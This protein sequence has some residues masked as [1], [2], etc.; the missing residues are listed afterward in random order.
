MGS[1]NYFVGPRPAGHQGTW[2]PAQLRRSV[3]RAALPGPTPADRSTPARQP[4]RE[5]LMTAPAT[6]VVFIH[7]LWLHATS[8]QPWIDLFGQAG[9]DPIA[10]GWPGE[11]DTVAEAREH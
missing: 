11:P 8:W 3:A 2:W 10:P 7:G 1:A 9:Y 6:P 4:E 5:L